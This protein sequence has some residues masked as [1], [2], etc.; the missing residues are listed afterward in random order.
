MSDDTSMHRRA[1]I[2]N[3]KNFWLYDSDNGFDLS[4]S[5]SSESPAVNPTLTIKT[6]TSPITIDPAKSALVI[7]DMQ[8]YFLR[9]DLPSPHGEEETLVG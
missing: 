8:N 9:Y 6:T 3:G 4:H 2:G 1:V 7:I 5:D